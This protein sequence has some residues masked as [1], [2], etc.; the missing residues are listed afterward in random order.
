MAILNNGPNGGFKGKVGSVVGYN[1]KGADVI[2]SLPKKSR[3]KPSKKQ[4]YNRGTFAMVQL[5][6]SPFTVFI[7]AGFDLE[8]Q[9]GT[10]SAFNKATSIN[11]INRIWKGVFPDIEI[12]YPKVCLSMGTLT[13]VKDPSVTAD[14]AGLHFNWTNNEDEEGV[15]YNDQIMLAAYIPQIDSAFFV[16]SGARRSEGSEMMKLPSKIKG[17]EIHTWMSFVSD[18]RKRISMSTYSGSLIF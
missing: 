1:R 14:D 12:D 10:G 9:K 16:L 17:M 7:R 4:Q 6:L 5:F 8:S 2:R 11:N 15:G 18:D 13:G 3:K